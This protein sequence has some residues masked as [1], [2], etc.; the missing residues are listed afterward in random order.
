MLSGA[1]SA[2]LR[3]AEHCGCQVAW[4]VLRGGNIALSTTDQL[5]LVRPGSCAASQACRAAT[6]TV[7]GEFVVSSAAAPSP[8]CPG[9]GR[10]IARPGD[11]TV[12]EASLSS[13]EAMQR[14]W[15]WSWLK[16]ALRRRAGWLAIMS[17]QAR[18]IAITGGQGP[19]D[20]LSFAVGGGF[21]P[22]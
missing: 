12:V 21:R 15:R 13:Y 16:F 22:G 14:T 17:S 2:S 19:R 20:G 10:S 5:L 11:G 4:R 6:P 8:T 18:V 9:M 7:Y 3:G 1:Y